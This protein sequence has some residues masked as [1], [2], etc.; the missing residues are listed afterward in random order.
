MKHDLAGD[1]AFCQRR[2]QHGIQRSR[3]EFKTL[4]QSAEVGAIDGLMKKT[5]T[6]LSVIDDPL[7]LFWVQSGIDR[8]RHQAGPPA[9][10]QHLKVARMILRKEQHP[11][12]GLQSQIAKRQRE[13]RRTRSPLAKCGP[14]RCAEK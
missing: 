10:H 14:D 8:D 13:G 6:R 7:N 12:A 9:A 1:H 5:N 3:L 11:I 2:G 4:L